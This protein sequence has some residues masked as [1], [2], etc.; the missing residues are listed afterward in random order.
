MF[1]IGRADTAMCN[2]L[3]FPKIRSR[4]KNFFIH[5]IL[6]T[7]INDS[8]DGQL[9]QMSCQPF[10]WPKRLSERKA[11]E[12]QPNREKTIEIEV[13]LIPHNWTIHFYIADLC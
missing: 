10:R 2:I 3:T 11:V 13:I 1:H 12:H 7:R 8:L 4:N 5:K 6:N 9:L